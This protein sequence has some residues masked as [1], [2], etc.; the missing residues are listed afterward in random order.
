[1]PAWIARFVQNVRN[2]NKRVGPLTTEEIEV[3]KKFWKEKAQRQGE[4]SEKLKHRR[5][6]GTVEKCEVVIIKGDELERAIQHL[7]PLELSCN[8]GRNTKTKLNPEIP[9]FRPRRN[10]AE[11]A[12]VR[13]SDIGEDENS[14]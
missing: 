14:N 11:V 6:S 5:S 1:M 2:K 7:Y 4:A 9:A 8:I 13:M 10:V 3:E 12:K